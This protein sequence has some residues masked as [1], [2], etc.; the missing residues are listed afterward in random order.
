MTAQE[1]LERCKSQPYALGFA[2]VQ[3]ATAVRICEAST[4]STGLAVI[5]F[6]RAALEALNATKEEP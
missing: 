1:H 3:I 5:G 2:T 6:V 4:D